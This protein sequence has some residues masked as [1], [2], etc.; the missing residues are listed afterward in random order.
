[1]TTIPF[2]PKDDFDLPDYYGMT[3]SHVNGKKDEFE[4]ATHSLKDLTRVY[5][6]RGDFKEDG[7]E[8]NLA[9][10]TCP[11]FEFVTRDDRWHIVPMSS[12]QRIEFDKNWSKIVEIKKKRDKE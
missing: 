7:R 10:A 3:I 4:I 1:M 2:I 6:T 8:F 9:V 5:C 11:F 12:I